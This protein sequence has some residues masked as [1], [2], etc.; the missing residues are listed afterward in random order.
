MNMETDVT[1]LLDRLHRVEA[2]LEI[3]S[4]KARYCAGCDD[5]HNADTLEA[6]FVPEGRWKCDAMSVDAQGHEQ[7]RAFFDG[8][9]NSGRIRNSQHMV[10][11]PDITVTGD[12]ATATWKMMMLYAGH[13][14]DGTVQFHRILGYYHDDFVFRDGRW[15]FE[16]LR[17][18]VEDTEAYSVEPSKFAG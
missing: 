10:S 9:A 17:P 14:P 1:A 3:M 6:L 4:L 2:Q 16:T 7:R 12:R 5:N 18:M 8:L 11:N 13:A 15:Y